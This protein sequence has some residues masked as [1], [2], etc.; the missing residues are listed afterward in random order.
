MSSIK[1]PHCGLVNF[2]TA[3]NCKRCN[4]ELAATADSTASR[5]PPGV[6]RSEGDPA[7]TAMTA[8]A[9]P[10][11]LGILLIV[12][13]AT[14][15]FAGVYLLAIGSSSLYFLVVGVGVAASGVLIAAGKRAGIYVYFATFGI[16]FIWSLIETGGAVGQTLSRLF[17]AAL[18]GLYLITEKVRARLN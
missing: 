10:R 18:I 13:G 16:M 1:C 17:I 11:S 7:A 2:S 9:P 4:R 8:P 15:C 12:L 3:V 14:L 5:Q 6:R